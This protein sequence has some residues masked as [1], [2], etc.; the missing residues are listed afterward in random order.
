[1]LH[2]A[3]LVNRVFTLRELSS[4]SVRLG[5]CVDKL[6]SLRE[7]CIFC[8]CWLLELSHLHERKSF[9]V[10]RSGLHELPVRSVLPGSFHGLHVMRGGAFPGDLGGRVLQGMCR[11]NFRHN[12]RRH[13]IQQLRAVPPGLFFRRGRKQLYDLRRRLLRQR[14]GLQQLH[15]LCRGNEPGLDWPAKLLDL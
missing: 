2:R 3:V 15:R 12:N 6:R 5:A 10:H 7:P 9:H 1:M 14:D 4:W 13:V 8:K 11:G